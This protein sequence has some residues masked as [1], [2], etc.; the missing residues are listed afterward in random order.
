MTTLTLTVQEKDIPQAKQA[1]IDAI[2]DN[3]FPDCVYN[4]TQRKASKKDT[5]TYRNDFP[6]AQ[7]HDIP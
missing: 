6:T 5:N 1:L 2:S 4:G 7:A 3:D